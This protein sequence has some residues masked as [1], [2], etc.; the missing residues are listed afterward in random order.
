MSVSHVLTTAVCSSAQP[1]G[2]GS[3][4]LKMKAG[5]SGGISSKSHSWNVEEAGWEFS[6]SD[7][8]VQTWTS[9]VCANPGA[10]HASRAGTWEG[11]LPLKGQDKGD[12]K[13]VLVIL[14]RVETGR[15]GR[16]PW[17]WLLQLS[18]GLLVYIPAEE[19]TDK[20]LNLRA[21]VSLSTS[22]GYQFARAA[23]MKSYTLGDLKGRNLWSLTSGGW[24]S[25]SQGVSKGHSIVGLWVRTFSLPFP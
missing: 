17:S 13:I 15:R 18:K 7:P 12:Q 1:C 24:K 2:A 14:L 23:W 20:I 10:G 25:K 9:E 5:R 22:G 19:G 8:R 11:W 4:T 6:L 16:G 21:F 3:T